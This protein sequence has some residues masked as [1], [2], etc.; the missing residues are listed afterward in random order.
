MSVSSRIWGR[1]LKSGSSGLSTGSCSGGVRGEI[2][3]VDS[4][5]LSSI[6][7]SNSIESERIATKRKI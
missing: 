5:W 4:A 7:V 3:E 1:N 2:S 6:F